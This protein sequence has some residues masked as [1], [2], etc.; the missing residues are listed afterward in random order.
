[1]RLNWNVIA[2]NS[3]PRPSS[4]TTALVRQSPRSCRGR[5]SGFAGQPKEK[6]R[7]FGGAKVGGSPEEGRTQVSQSAWIAANKSPVNYSQ[8]IDR[9]E[10]LVVLK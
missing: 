3:S 2:D 5:H 9:S 6:P 1:M 7:R 10:C 4:G 8:G